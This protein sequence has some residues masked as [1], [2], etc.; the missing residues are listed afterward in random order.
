MS[1]LSGRGLPESAVLLRYC[2]IA[3]AGGQP[4]QFGHGCLF[5][6]A[7]GCRN[8][9]YCCGTAVLRLPESTPDNSDMDPE[10][11][12]LMGGG[13]PGPPLRELAKSCGPLYHIWSFLSPLRP[14]VLHLPLAHLSHRRPAF[15]R[16]PPATYEGRTL[17]ISPIRQQTNPKQH[18]NNS[19]KQFHGGG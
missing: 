11:Y 3:A 13:A 7:D 17:V 4:G 15:P 12:L 1:D 6:P 5:C 14:N 2:G 10:L 16:A 8:V 9:R 18:Q 19:D